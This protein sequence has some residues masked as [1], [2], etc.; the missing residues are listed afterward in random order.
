MKVFI[1][2]FFITF[3]LFGGILNTPDHYDK[4][5]AK[6]YQHGTQG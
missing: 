3:G 1:L 6:A 2:A 4:I 5:T